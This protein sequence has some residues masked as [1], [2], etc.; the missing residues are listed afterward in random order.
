M[1]KKVFISPLDWGLGH[2]TRC[3]PIIKLLSDM[4]CQVIIG[5]DG[6]T[7]ELLRKEFPTVPHLKFPGYNIDYP[8]NGSM[9]W[10]MVKSTKKIFSRITLENQYIEE[11]VDMHK[12]DGVISDNRYGLYHSSAPSVIISHQINIQAP[13]V[14]K[15]I[16]KSISGRFINKFTECWIPDNEGVNNLGGDLS[17]G[18]LPTKAKYVGPISRLTSFKNS[19]HRYDVMAI[20]SGPEPQRTIFENTIVPY[21]SRADFRSIVVLGTPEKY[22]RV[23]KG[24]AEIHSHLTASELATAMNNSNLIIS[25]P[26]YSTIMDLAQMGKKA[27]FV[28]TPGQTEQE[29][30]AKYHEQ[31]GH[32]GWSKQK[33]FD[34]QTVLQSVEKYSGI[35]KVEPN[36]QL[37]QTVRNFVNSL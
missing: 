18:G 8:K 12:I 20:I 27:F 9:A 3:V 21:L 5:A 6:A 17:H 4:G 35:P 25:R 26:G 28:P 32:T 37:E 1:A 7:L 34:L 30:L 23:D 14:L 10:H 29:Y 31:K 24:N 15:N 33:G 2:A 36:T 13:P 19:P 16:I 11:I 22:V